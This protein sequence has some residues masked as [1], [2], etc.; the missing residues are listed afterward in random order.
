MQNIISDIVAYIGNNVSLIATPIYYD[1]F[2]TP[3]GDAVMVRALPGNPGEIRYFDGS[4]SG[5]FPFSVFARSASSQTAY[6]Q[7]CEIIAALDMTNM[8]L[9]DELRVSVEATASPSLVQRVEGGDYT[10][11]AGF[12]LD[13]FTE[14]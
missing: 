1:M 6:D 7:L 9:T 5:G 13:Y 3:S 11:T 8:P 2:A 12:R 14:V 10:Y 4:R